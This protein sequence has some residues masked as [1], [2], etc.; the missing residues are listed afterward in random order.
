MLQTK[1][2]ESLS[3]PTLLCTP[4]LGITVNQML[5]EMEKAVEVGVDVVEIRLDCL[6]NFN[7]Q[8]DLEILIKQSP[9]PTLVTYRFLIYKLYTLWLTKKKKKKLIFYIG[10]VSGLSGKEV[11][12]EA[13]KLSVR[14]CFAWLCNWELIMLI[15]SLR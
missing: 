2:N 15:L 14:V 4:L 12:M 6:R 7:P 10:I 3:S 8:Q 13:M 1:S 9:L 11:D 5:I